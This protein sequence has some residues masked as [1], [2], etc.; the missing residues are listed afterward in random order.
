LE[1]EKMG[2]PS[3]PRHPRSNCF[4]LRL[5]GGKRRTE[6]REHRVLGEA[7]LGDWETRRHGEVGR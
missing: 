5:R 1:D 3:N 4:K 2:N 6:F 7:R